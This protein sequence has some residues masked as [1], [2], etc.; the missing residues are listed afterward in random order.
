MAVLNSIIL[1]VL[2]EIKK[3]PLNLKALCMAFNFNAISKDAVD[4]HLLDLCFHL[5]KNLTIDSDLPSASTYNNNLL[6]DI[7]LRY[8]N[9]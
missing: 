4:C 7:L 9:R 3:S 5:R 2:R 6:L 1:S 8:P